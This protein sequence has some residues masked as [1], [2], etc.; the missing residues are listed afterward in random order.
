MMLLLILLLSAGGPPSSSSMAGDAEFA[1][2][3]YERAEEAYS[4]ARSSTP[5]SAQYLWRLARL[6]V[7]RGDMAAHDRKEE[8]YRKALEYAQR[9][10][11][12]DSTIA[13]GHTWKAAA[14]GNIAMFEGSREK[15]RLCNE[16]KLE[17]DRALAIDSL[18]DVAYSILGS[19]YLTLGKVSW[20]ERQL[21]SMFLGS[22]PPGGLEE[23]EA[24]IRKAIAIAPGVV[25]H[26]FELGLIL[27][28]E[29]K[30]QEAIEAFRAAASLP[31]TVG[32]DTRTKETALHIAQDLE[33]N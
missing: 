4:A 31:T 5:D 20:F 25:R 2:L 30:K 10:I 32:S 18:D 6:Y 24:A 17:L 1:R 21:A 29:G 12:T 26:R 8:L 14:L 19:F 28:E 33:Q 13:G 23:A 15:I 3:D 7:C 27:K 11:R 16:I 22:L 9:C